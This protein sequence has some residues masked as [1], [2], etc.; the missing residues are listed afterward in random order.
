MKSYRRLMGIVLAVFLLLWGGVNIWLIREKRIEERPYMVE[1]ARTAQRMEQDLSGAGL[2][3]ESAYLQGSRYV[4][5][6][7]RCTSNEE[8]TANSSYNYCLKQ[9]GEQVYRF[10][11]VQNSSDGNR[12]L[13][14]VNLV[15]GLS[16]LLVLGVLLYIYR[17]II[18]PF[19]Q[20]ENVPYELSKGNLTLQLPEQKAKYFGKFIWGTNILRENI[21][22]RRQNELD[23]HREKKLLLLSLTHDIKTPLSVIKLNTQALLRGLYKEE[24]RKQEALQSISGKVSE[25]EDYVSQ[26]IRASREDF[27]DL[28]VKEEEFYLS[29]VIENLRNY[30]TDKLALK[31]TAFLIEEYQ[32]CLL[33]GDENRLVEVLQNL[34]ENAIKYGDG[35]EIRL[36]FEQEEGCRLITVANSGKP[37]A[38]EEVRNIFDSFYRGSNTAGQSGS[39]LGLY[40]CRQ[41]MNGMNGDIFVKQTPDRFC[42]TVVVRMCGE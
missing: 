30:Y 41:L 37:M 5:K 20:L 27:L 6:I 15:F 29:A 2:R 14:T 23:L 31:K 32:D 13:L 35:E 28:Q 34:M 11:Y 8:L 4:K 17:K 33:A 38:D 24:E 26:I 18:A 25:I 39:G 7:F 22:S 9:V 40:I 21:E 42:M 3:D 12:L 1:I 16:L 19:S 10:E 36:S